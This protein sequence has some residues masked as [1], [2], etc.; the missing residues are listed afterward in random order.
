MARFFFT[1]M[2]LLAPSAMRMLPQRKITLYG[3]ILAS[4][5]P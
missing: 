1:A 2:P 5:F 4:L 3:V